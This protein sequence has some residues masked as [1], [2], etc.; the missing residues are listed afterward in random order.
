MNLL[1]FADLH[2]DESAIKELKEKSK[3]ADLIVSA[4]DL[5]FFGNELD[6][7]IKELDSFG[8]PLLTI[9]GNHDDKNELQIECDKSENIIYLDNEIYVMKNFIFAGHSGNSFSL[10]DP[11]FKNIVKKV[12]DSKKGKDII[13]VTHQPPYDTELDYIDGFDHVGSK[14]YKDYINA[15][16][17]LLWI[18]GHIHETEGKVQNIKNC[19]IINP[20]PRGMLLSLGQG[21][22][23]V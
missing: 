2:G 12:T 13:M 17:P 10:E 6:Q 1:I 15:S 18:C 5:T 14:T 16:P 23:E 8:K 9:A 11:D 20:G 22:D 4:G 19:Q 3:Y 21:K 7:V